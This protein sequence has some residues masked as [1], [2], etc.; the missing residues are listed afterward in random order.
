M[1]L[2]QLEPVSLSCN[3]LVKAEIMPASS[4]IG[5]PFYC[6]IVLR[7][8]A[9]APPFPNAYF[10]GSGVFESYNFPKNKRTAVS[11]PARNPPWQNGSSIEKGIRLFQV[12]TIS[13]TKERAF[14]EKARFCLYF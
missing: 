12:Y 5:T 9:S 14:F 7:S 6:F 13:V 1:N 11:D 8:G 10:S 3:S 4:A 2:F